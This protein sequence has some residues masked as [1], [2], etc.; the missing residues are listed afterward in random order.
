MK[1]LTLLATLL[2]TASINAASFSAFAD[3][4]NLYVTMLLD[5]CNSH[6]LALDVDGLCRN[7]RLTK[8]YATSCG[9]DLIVRSTKMYC[10]KS[11]LEPV[12]FTLSLKKS[13]IASEAEE[14]TLRN[15]NGDEVTIELERASK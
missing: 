6:G 13:N 7:D 4:D 10:G 1:I 11:S 2:I 3:G 14:L 12:T 8:N 9:A 5:D 15:F